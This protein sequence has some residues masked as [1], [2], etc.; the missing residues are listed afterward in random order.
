L[1]QEEE[2]GAARPSGREKRDGKRGLAGLNLR[3]EGGEDFPFFI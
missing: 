2:K 1:G 3:R